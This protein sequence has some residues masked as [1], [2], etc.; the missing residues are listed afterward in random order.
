MEC[1]GARTMDERS[2]LI[3]R[4]TSRRRLRGVLA[5]AACV[6]IALV[7][8]P[9][10]RPSI[11]PALLEADPSVVDSHAHV[12]HTNGDDANA[13]TARAPLLEADMS[14]A[15]SHAHVYVDHT[16]G[17]DAN[18][19][20]AR[21]PLR[22]LHA[23]R[24]AARRARLEG[25][26][27]AA[28]VHLAAGTH[29][30]PPATTLVLSP[31]D[32]NTTWSGA[33]G[34]AEQ[35][36]AGMNVSRRTWISGGWHVPPGCWERVKYTVE[37]SDDDDSHHHHNDDDDDHHHRDDDDDGRHHHRD[38]DDDNSRRD[39]NDHNHHHDDDDDDE[40]MRNDDSRGEHDDDAG[41]GRRRRRQLLARAHRHH[42]DGSA[43][44]SY[45]YD[46]ANPVHFSSG[47]S[48][49]DDDALLDAAGVRAYSFS[50]ASWS[51]KGASLSAP[52]GG[53]GTWRCDLGAAGLP[54]P[55]TTQR[56][57][58]LR[59]GNSL[60][61]EAR[62][63]DAAAARP[64]TS[65]WLFVE[66]AYYAGANQWTIQ[67]KKQTRHGPLPGWLAGDG[68]WA[69]GY[70]KVFAKEAW[71]DY[72]AFITPVT[73][74]D[75]KYGARGQDDV[76]LTLTC[77]PTSDAL[78]DGDDGALDTGSRLYVYGAKEALS[79]G[80]WYHDTETGVLYVD[81]GGASETAARALLASVHVPTARA[82]VHVAG[83]LGDRGVPEMDGDFV[84]G[85]TFER[86]GFVDAD[87]AHDGWQAGWN[88]YAWSAGIP[89]DSALAISGG[90][91]VA[92]E[93]CSFSLLGGGGVRATNGS[94]GVRVKDSSFHRIGQ[95]AVMLTGN[96]TTQP[97]RCEVVGN[98]IETIG[99]Q[100]ASSAGV[101]CSACSDSTIAD[102]VI[103]DVPRWA[104][105]MRS[106]STGGPS[107]SMRNTIERNRVRG[108][109]KA[110]KDFG[111]ISVIGYEGSPL[112]GT[113]I[114][115]NC[116]R[117][118]VGV[119]GENDGSLRIGYE[120]FS[121]YLDNEASGYEVYGN[122]FN[123]ASQSNIFMHLGRGNRVWN[124]VLANSTAA[125][126]VGAP[127]QV[128]G[129]SG[130]TMNNTFSRNIVA[131]RRTSA[132]ALVYSVGTFEED[133]LPP[134]YVR[135]NL[136]YPVDHRPDDGPPGSPPHWWTES[137][138]TP[139][140]NWSMWRNHGYD[141]ESVIGDPLFVDVMNANFCLQEGS[142]ARYLG[143]E[144]IPE[145]IC[146][147]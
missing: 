125:A 66:Q 78:C 47:G 59:I 103:A 62:W 90:R 14:V 114:V 70:V 58:T 97:R 119:V 54:R 135:K 61:P 144:D 130:V 102:N 50:Y 20:T 127:L 133:Y 146:R 104:I 65:G 121:L 95:S 79:A 91:D 43:D 48:D 82:L 29:V 112:T 1:V 122:V 93:R 71:N 74:L 75:S 12:D 41:R 96:A 89:D 139:Y 38:D 141:R 39:D 10:L 113:R 64:W 16:N 110:T 131:Q 145:E 111:A 73:D 25:G 13:G 26:A 86:L 81:V 106:E 53:N 4:A 19:G 32:A 21:S 63:P 52:G 22:T 115:H 27:G 107:D 87:Y 68:S 46:D 124:N 7:K 45:L 72:D 143:F 31:D 51:H 123:H 101:Y 33:D 99:T 2:R 109:G 100:L 17:D 35:S 5:A 84:S 18:A 57:R 30:L 128:E 80:E 28:T 24:D 37:V 85:V 34:E 6:V 76:W 126:G 77:P 94:W 55:L 67:L 147:C 132:L 49:D 92:V 36:V 9:V 134:K 142:A 3:P 117:D 118:A 56:F 129:I 140:G 137:S 105:H 88:L 108:A 138:L 69:G 11:V 44:G 83:R 23:A 40:Q 98:V 136:Y 8:R 116:V 60:A 42:D 15:D 120:G